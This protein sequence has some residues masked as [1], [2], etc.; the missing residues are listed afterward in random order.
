VNITIDIDKAKTDF[1]YFW[2]NVL[3]VLDKSGKIVKMPPLKDYQKSSLNFLK[4]TL[5]KIHLICLS[6]NEFNYFI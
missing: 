3:V 6:I 5:L 2:N 4:R 1:E